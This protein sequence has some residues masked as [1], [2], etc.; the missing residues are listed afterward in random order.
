MR[1]PRILTWLGRELS[2]PNGKNLIVGRPGIVFYNDGG[3]HLLPTPSKGTVAAMDASNYRYLW[4]CDDADWSGAWEGTTADYNGWI[5]QGLYFTDYV[6]DTSRLFKDCTWLHQVNAGLYNF[7]NA[8][9]FKNVTRAESM[10]EGCTGLYDDNSFAL[11]SLKLDNCALMYK[12]CSDMVPTLAHS[13]YTKLSSLN[14]SIHHECFTGC[15]GDLQHIP[16]SWGG[17]GNG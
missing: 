16:A 2:A 6:T 4:T 13:I 14:P 15:G 5:V 7:G 9:T 1:N 10:F 12:N 3:T 11:F 17:T 8:G